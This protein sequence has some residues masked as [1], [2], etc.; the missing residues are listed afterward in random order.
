MDLSQF[1]RNASRNWDD[2]KAK[3]SQSNFENPPDGTYIMQL[4]G[5]ELAE[6][7][8][9]KAMVKWVWTIVEGD[10]IGKTKYDFTILEGDRGLEPLAWRL[11][12]MGIRLEDV[13]KKTLAT[14]N[15]FNG[16][17]KSL[18]DSGFVA[19]IQLKVKKGDY[20]NLKILRPLPNYE[21][22]VDLPGRDE[23]EDVELEIGM[24]VAWQSGKEKHVGV[25]KA[26]DEEAGTVDVEVNGEIVSV[27]ANKLSLT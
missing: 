7:Q 16:F 19:R 8:S 26:F 27:P 23:P 5:A 20:Q 24:T 3:A 10:L 22:P 15:A 13:E 4:T 12:S 21:G 11:Q 2:V 9:G 14:E 25:V 17:L 18:V 6:S 1:M